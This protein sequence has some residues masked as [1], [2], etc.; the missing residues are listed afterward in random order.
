MKLI[1]LS[2]V[3][4]SWTIHFR[5]PQTPSTVGYLPMHT[6]CMYMPKL[7][8]HWDGNLRSLAVANSSQEK[9][10][11][12]TLLKVINFTYVAGT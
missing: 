3:P 9:K 8:W 2:Q 10:N 7:T 12:T 4:P 1:R 6:S 11:S 5:A